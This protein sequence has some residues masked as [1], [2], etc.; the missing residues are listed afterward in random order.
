MVLAHSNVRLGRPRRHTSTSHELKRRHIA[1]DLGE[2][3]TTLMN[4]RRASTRC[5]VERGGPSGSSV[6]RREGE[7]VF[8]FPGC[9]KSPSND[10]FKKVQQSEQSKRARRANALHVLHNGRSNGRPNGRSKKRREGKQFKQKQMHIELW[11]EISMAKRPSGDPA[12]CPADLRHG[13]PPFPKA[14]DTYQDR[15]LKLVVG[16]FWDAMDEFRVDLERKEKCGVFTKDAQLLVTVVGYDVEAFKY[17]V[18]IEGVDEAQKY[19]LPEGMSATDFGYALLKL[20]EGDGWVYIARAADLDDGDEEKRKEAK[21]KRG[22]DP[23]SL[24]VCADLYTEEFKEHSGSLPHFGQERQ[25]CHLFSEFATC[26]IRIYSLHRFPDVHS[27][28]RKQITELGSCDS[29]SNYHGLDDEGCDC[30]DC[31]DCTCDA[32]DPLLQ[33]AQVSSDRFQLNEVQQKI[34]Q[35]IDAETPIS[36][37]Q[38]PPGTGKSTFIVEFVQVRSQSRGLHIV[39]FNLLTFLWSAGHFHFSGVA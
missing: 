20:R 14:A 35:D 16:E 25:H 17:I 3:S 23:S 8:E 29:S 22:L 24:T 7:L 39:L 26:L 38:G 2:N 19:A 12:F 6:N 27:T 34:A 32:S 5:Y 9:L 30:E 13:P 37:V 33:H 31:E 1:T 21:M 11:H 15:W 4:T 10:K 36:F 28:I 18:N